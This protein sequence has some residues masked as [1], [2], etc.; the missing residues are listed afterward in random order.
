M[1]A[2]YRWLARAR[3]AR[4][5]RAVGSVNVAGAAARWLAFGALARLGLR[6]FAGPAGGARRWL[7]A[8]VDGLR[9]L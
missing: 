7:R 6:R 2:T 1:A 3:G 4:L 9:E 5:A 8:H